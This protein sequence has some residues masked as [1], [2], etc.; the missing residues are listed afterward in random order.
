MLTTRALHTN[1]HAHANHFPSIGPAWMGLFHLHDVAQLKLFSLQ[2]ESLF[3]PE[4]SSKTLVS[5]N[6]DSTIILK[7]DGI[8]QLDPV[9]SDDSGFYFMTGNKRMTANKKRFKMP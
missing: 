3:L 6:D 7:R 4:P 8:Y 1:I 9:S 2:I 5:V